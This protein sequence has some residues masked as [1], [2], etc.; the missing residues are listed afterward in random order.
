MKSAKAACFLDLTEDWLYGCFASGVQSCA[1]RRF[2]LSTHPSSRRVWVGVEL[3]LAET[4]LGLDVDQGIHL[5][6]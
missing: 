2:E 4:M 5:E 3:F 1:I 6:P